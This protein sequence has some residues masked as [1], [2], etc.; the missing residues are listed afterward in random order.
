MTW[1]AKIVF[2]LALLPSF[3][4]WLPKVLVVGGGRGW[5]GGQGWS[6]LVKGGPGWLG[7]EV[8]IVSEAGKELPSR[9]G[10]QQ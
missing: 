6:G 3:C 1:F 9:F 2:V 7:A 10:D 4:N 5:L 8:E